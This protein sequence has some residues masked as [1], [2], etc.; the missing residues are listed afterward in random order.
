LGITCEHVIMSSE[1]TTYGTLARV[2]LD[3]L[4]PGLPPD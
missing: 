1:L 3:S 4:G 2:R